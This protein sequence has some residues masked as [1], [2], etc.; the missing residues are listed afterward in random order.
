MGLYVPGGASVKL[1]IAAASFVTQPC[2][3]S[4]SVLLFEVVLSSAWYVWPYHIH[5]V[6]R[7]VTLEQR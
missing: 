3:P 5:E 7:P 4:A 2:T 1:L 6:A